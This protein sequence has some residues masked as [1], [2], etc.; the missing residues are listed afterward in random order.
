[1]RLKKPADGVIFADDKFEKE[2]NFLPGDNW[3]K[4]ALLKCI[5]D[6]KENVFAGEHIPKKLIPDE[7]KRKYGVDNL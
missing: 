4:K 2:F 1:M 7:Y 3:L 6:L 5:N